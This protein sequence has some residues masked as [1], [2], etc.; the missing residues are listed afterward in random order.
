MLAWYGGNTS[1][2]PRRLSINGFELSL[3]SAVTD[4]T[5]REVF[6]HFADQCRKRAGVI[7]G[8]KPE[9]LLDSISFADFQNLK[10]GMVRKE[11]EAQGTI[12]CIDTER[13][14]EA[15]EVLARIRRYTVTRD[16]ADVGQLRA[17]SARRNGAVTQLLM[18]GSVGE[19][20]L[21]RAFCTTGDVPGQEPNGV[22]RPPESRRVFDTSEHEGVNAI[23]VYE[24]PGEV[25][26]A[27]TDFYRTELTLSGWTVRDS[28]RPGA[29]LAELA[30]RRLLVI[31]TKGEKNELKTSLVELS[32]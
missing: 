29:F 14:L 32:R 16:F 19:M 20:K 22:P 24:S 25:P 2:A 12:V 31:V 23:H 26:E 21:D 15:Q 28:R 18:I 11:S 8:N 30:H 7:T 3:E 1:N 13:P 4:A 6:D 27:V 9:K 17:L 10:S 5:I